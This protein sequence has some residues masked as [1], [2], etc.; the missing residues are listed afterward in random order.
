MRSFKRSV[1]DSD[2]DLNAALAAEL[3]TLPPPEL[4]IVWDNLPWETQCSYAEAKRHLHT[5]FG[6]KSIIAAFQT[7]P[8]A[9]HKIANLAMEVYAA[10]E[11][12]LVKEASPT[13][14]AFLHTS[15]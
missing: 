4:F 3:T 5:A 2:V 12:T 9:C 1:K 6:Q 11:C 7:F 13:F 10:D 8:N 15:D 14:W